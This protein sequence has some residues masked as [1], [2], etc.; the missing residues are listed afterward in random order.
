MVQTSVFLSYSSKDAAFTDGLEADLKAAGATVY[1]VSASESGDFQKR[2]NDALAACEWVVLVLTKDALASPWVEQEINAA[3]RLKNQGRIRG[4]LPVQAGSVNINDLPPL[5]GV[6]NIFDA[7]RGY[8]VAVADVCHALDL[9]AAP[10]VHE[11]AQDLVM[12]GR[13][14]SAQ[15]KLA[16]SLVLFQR[17]TQLD[18]RSFDAWSNV[19]ATLNSLNRYA[20]ALPAHEQATTLD[21]D[22]AIAWKNKGD[23]LSGLKRYEEALVANQRAA[24]LNPSLWQ[25]WI[26]ISVALYG[27]GR[28]DEAEEAE[29]RARELRGS[30]G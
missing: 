22:D 8:P 15:G 16:E 2:I 6:F 28:P 1:R 27:L 21:P 12:R 29:R 18:P 24:E 25:A 3:I 7:T 17:A 13:A 9:S 26:G 19:G 30:R 4:V 10:Q 20:E 5:W 14:L 23:A 11:S